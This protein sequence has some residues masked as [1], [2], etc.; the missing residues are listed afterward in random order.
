MRIIEPIPT[1]SHRN[2]EY[3]IQNGTISVSS[4]FSY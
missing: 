3:T 4:V 1:L 2:Y